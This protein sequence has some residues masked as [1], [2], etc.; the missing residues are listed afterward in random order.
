MD[1]M[2]VYYSR[3]AEVFENHWVTSSE[4]DKVRGFS[5]LAVIMKNKKINIL[6]I[7]VSPKFF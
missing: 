7:P 3:S 2:S 1:L 4:R 5:K 6:D